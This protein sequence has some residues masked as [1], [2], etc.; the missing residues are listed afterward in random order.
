MDIGRIWHQEVI[1]EG[2]CSR[3]GSTY[4]KGMCVDE[5]AEEGVSS[6]PSTSSVSPESWV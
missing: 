5:G 2:I 4:F 6:C 1:K 3:E